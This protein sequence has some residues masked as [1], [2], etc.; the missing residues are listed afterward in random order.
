MTIEFT[1]ARRSNIPL[2]LGVAGPTGSGKSF[3]A[4]R[5]ATG[6]SG[7]KPFAVI[8][9]EAGRALHY[10]DS[11][12]FDHASLHPPFTPAAYTE[13]ITAADNAGYPVIVVDSA[14]HEYAGE[15]GMLDIQADEFERMGGRDSAKM[16][17]W[18][19]PKMEHKKF[20]SRLLQLRAHLILCF[21]AEERIE[22][23]KEGGKTVVR[24]KQSPTGL[25]G[26]MPVA[27]KNFAYELTASFLL[28]A[29][30]PGVPKPIKLPEALRSFVPL[31]KPLGEATGEGLGRW[32][33]GDVSAPAES[34][35]S[36]T[37]LAG[38][39]DELLALADTLGRRESVMV[40]VEKQRLKHSPVQHAAW[41]R[42]QIGR[43]R[44]AVAALEVAP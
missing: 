25:A 10:A 21:R 2:L 6:L 35:S 27:E 1:E 40:M 38:L 41:L 32:A 20:V 33:A 9:T 22:I 42:S 14:S 19:K 29:D 34:G 43:A 39:E 8:D 15:G 18:I 11:F 12:S 4:L 36:D 24:P 16:S 17:S 5:L 7:G 23:V 13:A 28:T 3:S 26:W 31:D 44:S 30:Q 37:E